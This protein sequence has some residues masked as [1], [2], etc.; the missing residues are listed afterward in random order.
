MSTRQTICLLLMPAFVAVLIFGLVSS[1]SSADC[2]QLSDACRKGDLSAVERLLGQGVDPNC[3]PTEGWTPLIEAAFANHKE[4]ASLLI[5]K[6]ANVDQVDKTTGGTALHISS[7]A[8]HIEFVGYLLSV[9]ADINAATSKGF[10]A[11]MLA[12]N[13]GRVEVARRLIQANAPVNARSAD[14][15]TALA[16]AAENGQTT[17]VDL[18][19]ESGAADST[20]SICAGMIQDISI[21]PM[22]GPVVELRLRECPGTFTIGLE[23]AWRYGLVTQEPTEETPLVSRTAVISEGTRVRII[24]RTGSEQILEAKVFKEKSTP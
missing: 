5:K 16:L 7:V 18:L 14:G 12:S 11:L 22:A 24:S 15:R 2:A 23:L 4:I 20:L 21:H 1:A 6:G 17:V 13:K 10:T 19:L 9:G 8:G 3:E